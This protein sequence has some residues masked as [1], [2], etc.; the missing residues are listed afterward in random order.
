[1]IPRSKGN[2]SNIDTRTKAYWLG[3]MCAR[4]AVHGDTLSFSSQKGRP[5]QLHPLISFLGQ[6]IPKGRREFNLRSAQ[7]IK[8]LLR[9]TVVK[10]SFIN[11]PLS[12]NDLT[13]SLVLGFL[14]G[15]G[16]I[17]SKR[18]IYKTTTYESAS[19][20]FETQNL[21]SLTPLAKF[22]AERLDIGVS[23][24]IIIGNGKRCKITYQGAPALRIRDFLYENAPKCDSAKR[25]AFFAFNYPDKRPHDRHQQIERYLKIAESHGGKLLSNYTGHRGKIRL[26]CAKGHEW[27]SPASSI[28]SGSWCKLCEADKL[29]GNYPWLSADLLP[30]GWWDLKENRIRYYRWLGKRGGFK[31]PRDWYAVRLSAF[32]PTLQKRFDHSKELILRDMFPG[33]AFEPWKFINLSQGFWQDEENQREFFL[34]LAVQKKFSKPSD[35]YRAVASDFPSA[36]KRHFNNDFRNII[37]KM[38]PHFNYEPWR[39]G[40]VPRSYWASKVNRRIYLEWLG[41][42][43]GFRE[44]SDWYKVKSRD[45]SKFNGVT[46]LASYYRRSPSAAVIDIFPEWNLNPWQFDRVPPGFWK[47]E[48]NQRNYIRWLGQEL[49]ITTPEDWY[50]VQARDFEATLLRAY[51]WS[52]Y[53][54]LT[55]LVRGFKPLPWL[56]PI[57]P[58]G[59]WDKRANQ[60]RYIAWLGEKLGYKKPVDWYQV[61]GNDIISSL[62]KRYPGGNAELL[63][64]LFPEWNLHPSKFRPSAIRENRKWS[65]IAYQRTQLQSLGKSLGFKSP[66]DWYKLKCSQIPHWLLKNYKSNPATLVTTLLPELQLN[67]WLFS[68]TPKYHWDNENSIQEFAQWF[69]AWKKIKRVDQWYRVARSDLPQA[70]LLRYSNSLYKTVCALVPGHSFKPWLFRQTAPNFWSNRQNQIDYMDWLGRQKNRTKP[71]HWY[72]ASQGE[73]H[74]SFLKQFKNSFYKALKSIFPKFNFE[75]WQFHRASSGAWNS[76]KEQR[77]YLRW[78]AKRLGLKTYEDWYKVT[79]C[80]FKYN[81]GN[82]LASKY[83][84]SPFKILTSLIPNYKWAPEKFG[85]STT[86]QRAVFNYTKQLFRACRVEW[87]HKHSLLR[88]RDSNRAM[89]LDIFVPRHRL[90]IEYHGRQHYIPVEHWGGEENLR[91]IQARDSEKRLACKE[92]GIT[93][94]EVPFS[95][96]G[97]RTSFV[98]LLQEKGFDLASK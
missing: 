58:T 52:P 66:R 96:D 23:K 89:E 87:N 68:K 63:N 90:G 3:F 14:D 86:R 21:D 28:L 2:F 13:P 48:K 51:N 19:L 38:I 50:Q 46:L 18:T 55:K 27:S 41:R 8:S 37:A 42:R 26:R 85:R 60:R 40:R 67:V 22:F 80:D 31:R 70:L 62:K 10:N 75:F 59:F 69:A 65:A 71:E 54:I 61:R 53:K 78:L 97:T 39:F 84:S 93:L 88:F 47:S 12:L 95:W 25:K 49:K 83:R 29:H 57:V 94:V 79:I 73:F 56:L 5:N 34:R 98:R 7:L 35:W 77:L 17:G 1:M 36:L 44:A 16:N 24:V 6:T 74:H 45:F 64:A 33:Y 76:L 91:L 82:W 43:L 9:H 4:G 72:E 32:H 81:G 30:S 20:T 92:A 15:C 11:L